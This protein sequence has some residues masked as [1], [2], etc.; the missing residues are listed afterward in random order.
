MKAVSQCRI[1]NPAFKTIGKFAS[2]ENLTVQLP[3][4]HGRPPRPQGL[5][6]PGRVVR[7]Q[8]ETRPDMATNVPSLRHGLLT[9]WWRPPTRAD[10]TF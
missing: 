5:G 7:C 3:S 10:S 9:L 2:L 6:M 8:G 4:F 1:E